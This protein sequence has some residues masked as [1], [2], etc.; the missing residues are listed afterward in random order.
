MW[1]PSIQGFTD[2]QDVQSRDHRPG[3]C[4][5]CKDREEGLESQE[6]PTPTCPQFLF[7]QTATAAPKKQHWPSAHLSGRKE[8]LNLLLS[9]YKESTNLLAK[10]IIKERLTFNIWKLKSFF[11]WLAKLRTTPASKFGLCTSSLWAQ[12]DTGGNESLSQ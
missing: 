7:T 4:K 3:T 2:P 1:V 11:F 10:G 12:P 8:L 5:V 6:F 9:H